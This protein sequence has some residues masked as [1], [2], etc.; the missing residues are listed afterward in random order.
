MVAEALVGDQLDG[1]GD[2]RHHVH[3]LDQRKEAP[4]AQD[5]VDPAVAA[6]AVVG[7]SQVPEG[8]GVGQE[9]LARYL[10]HGLSRKR[11]RAT[12]IGAH[13]PLRLTTRAGRR[14]Q[15]HEAQRR[16]AGR[17]L[18]QVLVHPLPHGLHSRLPL[19]LA[20][21]LPAEGGK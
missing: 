11:R 6:Q 17:Q 10:P 8:V 13:W 15:V 12:N 20:L 3:L 19:L 1:A 18:R 4:G 14:V 16:T 21:Q 9:V 2:L 5:M 7:R